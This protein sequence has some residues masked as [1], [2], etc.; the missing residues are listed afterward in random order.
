MATAMTRPIAP[1]RKLLR[2]FQSNDGVL[3][4]RT[5]ATATRAAAPTAAGHLGQCPRRPTM[6]VP[7]A[8]HV[9]LPARMSGTSYLFGM[10]A[11]Y[12]L[13]IV[14]EELMRSLQL[15]RAAAA[16]LIATAVVASVSAQ[17]H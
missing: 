12:R 7:R 15:V 16:L 8:T 17:T 14:A 3:R 10:T 5:T 2:V 9:R 1:N 4:K 6:P 11:L 13:I